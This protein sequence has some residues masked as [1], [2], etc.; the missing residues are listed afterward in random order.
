MA[1]FETVHYIERTGDLGVLAESNTFLE[2]QPLKEEE[3]ERY[4]IPKITQ[5]QGSVY[6]H[7]VRTIERG[8][9]FGEHGLPLIGSGDWNDGF[10][11]IG[12]KGKRESF[13]GTCHFIKG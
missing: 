2:D 11:R 10:S 13:T 1:P 3:D 4:S 12:P 7:C 8:L 6:E 9:R 5:E